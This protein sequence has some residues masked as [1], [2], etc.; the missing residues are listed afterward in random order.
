MIKCGFC[1]LLIILLSLNFWIIIILICG[2]LFIFLI[3]FFPLIYG[4]NVF[5]FIIFDNLSFCLVVLRVWISIIII[6]ARY[7]IFYKKNYNFFFLK[8]FYFCCYF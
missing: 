3:L 8:L 2:L 6:L 7:L 1:L 5:S 4:R